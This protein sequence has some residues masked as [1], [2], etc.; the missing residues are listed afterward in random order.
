ML[1]LLSLKNTKIYIIISTALMFSHLS[2]QIYKNSE[3]GV[4]SKLEVRTY[5]F[6]CEI[7]YNLFILFLWKM[8]SLHWLL[9]KDTNSIDSLI[10]IDDFHSKFHLVFLVETEACVHWSCNTRFLSFFWPFLRYTINGLEE[11][12]YYSIRKFLEQIT[13]FLCIVMELNSFDIVSMQRV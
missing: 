2:K 5:A 4:F 12:I 9:Y 3:N 11:H 1:H 13:V 6:L 7:R 10:N 8:L